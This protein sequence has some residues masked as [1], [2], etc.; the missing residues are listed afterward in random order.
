MVIIRYECAISGDSLDVDDLV[1]VARGRSVTLDPHCV[2]RLES[3]ACRRGAHRAL[4]G[5][6]PMA[7]RRDSA[8]SKTRSS[9]PDEV[10]QLTAQPCAQPRRRRRPGLERAES[11]APCCSFAPTRS[12]LGH[13]GV[14]PQVVQ[15]LL[16]MLNAG[17]LSAHPLAGLAGRQRR[18]GAPGASGPGADWRGG[19]FLCRAAA[20]RRRGSAPR[21]LA[22]FDAGRQGRVGPAQRHDADGRSGRSERTPRDQSHPDRRYRCGAD[23]GGAQRH[24]SRL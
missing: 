1:A 11:C 20:S 16:D 22:P 10:R 13:S 23:P 5:G 15:L 19:G 14:R 8:V 18:S 4:K 21:Q 7:S 3:L 2:S 12:A 17:V 9:P 24:R 6:S